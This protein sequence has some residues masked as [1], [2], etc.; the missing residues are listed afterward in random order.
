MSSEANWAFAFVCAVFTVS[1]IVV[2]LTSVPQSDRVKW[3]KD[4]GGI[5][6]YDRNNSYE[7]CEIK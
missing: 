2:G 5:A 4:N 6:K 7:G 1:I 3:C